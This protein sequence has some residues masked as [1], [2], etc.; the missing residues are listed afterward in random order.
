MARNGSL[1]VNDRR[2]RRV[3]L[4]LSTCWEVLRMFANRQRYFLLPLVLILL[5]TAILLLF[6]ETVPV[7]GPFVYTIF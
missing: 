5:L 7:F 3:I 1:L 4:F 2:S 6:A